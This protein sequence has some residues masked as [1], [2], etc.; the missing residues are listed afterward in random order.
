[1]NDN[2]ELDS[3]RINGEEYIIKG[4]GGESAGSEDKVNI[5]GGIIDDTIINKELTIPDFTDVE[6]EN[7]K[8][9]SILEKG[10]KVISI[11]ESILSVIDSTHTY[12]RDL[13]KTKVN[14]TRKIAGIDLKDDITAD[15]LREVIGVSSDNGSIPD[16]VALLTKQSKDLILPDG[17]YDDNGDYVLFDKESTSEIDVDR[18]LHLG[19]R[20]FSNVANTNVEREKQYLFFTTV[21][22]GN[23]FGQTAQI[24]S[25]RT[26][27]LFNTD[28]FGR[29]A[30]LVKSLS[31]IVTYGRYGEYAASSYYPLFAYD[32]KGNKIY[33]V[34]RLDSVFTFNIASSFTSTNKS[35]DSTGIKT[36]LIISANDIEIGGAD[37]DKYEYPTS[38]SSHY[39][40][41]AR[42]TGNSI[43]VSSDCYYISIA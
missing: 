15:E 34:D 38:R 29:V 24:V 2:Q 21:Y 41:L 1:M 33:D 6:L 12:L 17:C 18:G 19:E 37:I 36:F 26:S 22:D 5:N 10:S 40:Y 3:I 9:E 25:G 20:Y 14:T 27:T 32:T 13:Y 11:L 42:A 43:T 4:S 16:N 8:T 28:N 35:I 7:P 30:A 39:I 23:N 31:N